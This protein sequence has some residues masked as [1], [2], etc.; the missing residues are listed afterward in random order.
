MRVLDLF[1]GI[2]GFSIGLEKSG[3]ETAAFCE[4]DP[5]A[6]AVLRKKWKDV[7]IHDDIR[8]LKGTEYGPIDVVCGGYPCQPFSPLGKR[9]GTEDARYLFPEMLRV[10]NACGARWVVCE[11][12]YEHVY[13]G[14]DDVCTLLEDSGFSVWPFIIPASSVGARH[15]RYRLWIVAHANSN[16]FKPE[17]VRIQ[18]QG[19]AEKSSPFAGVRPYWERAKPPVLGMDDGVS[20]KSHRIR[21][22]GNA[23]FTEIPE[24]I[25][26]A[27]MM[28]EYA[29]RQK[30][31]FI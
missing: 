21:C 22:C 19:Q 3:M 20:N 5:Y 26:K 25:G 30:D 29:Q 17:G 7:P 9:C 2:G 13:I 16:G 4:I 28:I 23:V 27:I 14:F 15:R 18:E 1:S 31:M 12:V 10:I 6:R 11:N 24:R 8:T